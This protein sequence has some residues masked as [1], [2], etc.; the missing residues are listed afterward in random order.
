MS[1]SGFWFLLEQAGSTASRALSETLHGE[2]HP[3]IFRA[4]AYLVVAR[5]RTKK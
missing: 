4:L 1:S 2:D 5:P 3:E